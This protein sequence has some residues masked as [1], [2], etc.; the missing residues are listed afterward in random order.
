MTREERAMAVL[1]E[2]WTTAG[3]VWNEDAVKAMI[4][5]ADAEAAAMRERAAGVVDQHCDVW[6]LGYR[7][8]TDT[9]SAAIR[10]L[11]TTEK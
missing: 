3:K 1:Q 11:P 2:R 4:Q 8:M 6:G 5:F 7:S 9:I 10:A